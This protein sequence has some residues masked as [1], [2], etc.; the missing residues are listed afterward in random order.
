MG[1]LPTSHDSLLIFIPFIVLFLVRR[2]TLVAPFKHSRKDFM[3][4]QL[5]RPDPLAPQERY[6]S[7][8][9]AREAGKRS[10]TR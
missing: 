2:F 7:P 1:I 5:T 8:Q 10:P 9:E 6:L 4:K 3:S